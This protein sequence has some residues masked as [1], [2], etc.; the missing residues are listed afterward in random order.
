MV[1]VLGVCAAAAAAMTGPVMS[2]LESVEPG[3]TV[4]FVTSQQ[5][6]YDSIVLGDLPPEG[7]FQV[8]VSGS[9]GL[10]TEFGPG[11]T[12]YLGGRWAL[13]MG[14]GQTKYFS[15]PLIGRGHANP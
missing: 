15:C 11:D 13:D 9:D 1:G 6:Y 2:Q 5:L 10:E 12:G 3:A 14:G 4:V 7:P 8:L